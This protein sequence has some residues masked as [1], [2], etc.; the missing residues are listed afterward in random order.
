MS[1]LDLFEQEEEIDLVALEKEHCILSWKI[2]EWKIAYYYPHLIHPSR[3]ADHT[4]SD[5]EYDKAEVRYLELCKQLG[6]RN[7]VVHKIYPGYDDYQYAMFEIDE[8]RYS[9]QLVIKKLSINKNE[10]Y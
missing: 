1:I 6:K 5:D 8:K 7:T 10:W 4:V 2:I 9:V 3:I